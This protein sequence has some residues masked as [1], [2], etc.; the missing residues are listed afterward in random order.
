MGLGHGLFH[1]QDSLTV[2]VHWFKVSGPVILSKVPSEVLSLHLCAKR[3]PLHAHCLWNLNC[4]TTREPECTSTVH[5]AYLV[6]SP[7]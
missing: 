4:P 5:C 3:P 1:K 7:W 2:L 6:G